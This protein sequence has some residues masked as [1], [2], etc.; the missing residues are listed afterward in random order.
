MD[1][2]EYINRVYELAEESWADAWDEV[3]GWKLGRYSRIVVAVEL[4]PLWGYAYFKYV[5]PVVVKEGRPVLYAAGDAYLLKRLPFRFDVGIYVGFSNADEFI[6]LL[7]RIA[8]RVCYIKP[9]Y[10]ARCQA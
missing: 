10:E 2:N 8:N 3:V 4:D 6:S 9:T 1:I 5:Y 7:S